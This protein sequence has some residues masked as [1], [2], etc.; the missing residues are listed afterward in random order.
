MHVYSAKRGIARLSVAAHQ[1]VSNI[2]GI[3]LVGTGTASRISHRAVLLAAARGLYCKVN[4]V[5]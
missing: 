3:A 1:S 4:E 2:V 5:H